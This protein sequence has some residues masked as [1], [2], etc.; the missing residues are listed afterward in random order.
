MINNYFYNIS[1]CTSISSMPENF[2]DLD[3]EYIF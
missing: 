1:D 3:E 2:S